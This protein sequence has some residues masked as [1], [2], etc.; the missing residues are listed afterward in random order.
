MSLYLL[1]PL[2]S[3]L[4]CSA[5]V[6]ALLF[7]HGGSRAPRV[8]A[9]LVSGVGLW[10]LSETC[11]Q[12]QQ[13]PA[14]AL[15]FVRAATLGWAWI[16]PL[17]L[18]LFLELAGP[19][20]SR[21]RRLLPAAYG[22]AALIVAV[23][24]FTPWLQPAVI[25]TAWGWSYEFGPAYPFVHVFTLACVL[26]G[27][28]VAWRSLR[29]QSSPGEWQQARWVGLGVS[30]PLVVASVTD[31]LL[32]LF[33]LH[34]PRLG[35]LSFAVLGCVVLWS[36]HRYGY[37]LLAPG[38][39]ASEILE[40]LP[41]GVA[42]V[43][44]DGRVRRANGALARMLEAEPSELEGMRI[45]DWL[46]ES[47][48]PEDEGP[49]RRCDL[50]TLRGRRRPVAVSSEELVDR[51]GSPIGRAWVLRNL[52]EVVA[53][54]DRLLLSGR[55]AAVGQLAA[56]IAHE[57]ANPLAY[58]RAN[59][60]LMR[61]HWEALGTALEKAGAGQESAGLLGE[62][63]EVLDETLE[64]VDRAVSIVRDVRGMAH[65][66]RQQRQAS[67]LPQLLE[68]VLRLA[69]PQLRSR[70][71]VERDL[72]PVPPVVCAPQE[73][74]QVFL[75][76]VLNAAQAVA[77]GGRVRVATRSGPRGVVVDVEDDGI[78]IDPEIRDRIFDPFFTT[79]SVGEGTGLGLG[80]A[81][82]IV[83]SHGGEIEVESSPGSGT[84]FS[85]HLPA[86]ADTIEAT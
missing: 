32:P 73:L 21:K 77:P 19:T 36:F 79:K 22:V 50:V 47:D 81:Y 51:Q 18:D 84:R 76:L 15:F 82:G 26:W 54:R 13:E 9:A 6:S 72:E 57:I 28:L 69:S 34:V 78:G 40:A 4:V 23:S 56:G 60:G 41:D 67:D 39:F 11:W 46:C 75:N 42:M 68:G 30:V 70:V 17:A 44:L 52:E 37:S 20:E 27:A 45:E 58:V 31:G 16:G 8:V 71:C 86:A 2:L 65:G 63:E 3:C 10:A 12:I 66:G 35:T 29:L 48:P 14:H 38:D 55:L 59:L 7:R 5:L 61:E 80:I 49:E 24:W 53:L 74:Q 1:V 85:V 64:G 43:R 33:G 83:R 25:R 62:G